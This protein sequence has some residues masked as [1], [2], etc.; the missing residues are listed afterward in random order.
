MSIALKASNKTTKK[1]A[2][3]RHLQLKPRHLETCLHKN[4]TI[5]ITI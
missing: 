4:C 5:D 3:L 2:R 1:H